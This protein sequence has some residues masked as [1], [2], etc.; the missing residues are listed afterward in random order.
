MGARI[1]A[2]ADTFDAMTSERPYRA[3]SMYQDVCV[4]LA[5][6]AGLQFDPL[7]VEVFMRIPETT[8]TEL[9]RAVDLS[10]GHWKDETGL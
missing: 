9:R 1:F 4:E 10:T 3:M 6:C 7:V 2:V 5:K 8:W